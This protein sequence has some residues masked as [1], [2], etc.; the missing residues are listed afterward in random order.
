MTT[1]RSDALGDAVLDVPSLSAAQP[2]ITPYWRKMRAPWTHL[3][4]RAASMALTLAFRTSQEP[5]KQLAVAVAGAASWVPKARI[6]NMNEGSFD[7]RECILAPTPATISFRLTV[8][9]RA[10][11]RLSPAVVSPLPQT[12]VF[13]VVV[14]DAAGSEHALSSTRIAGPDA[15]NWGDL[16]LD[17]AAWG[18][19]RVELRLKTSTDRPAP[20]ERKW[21]PP[22]ASDAGTDA[23]PADVLA[24]PTMSVALWGDPVIVAEQPTRVP[25]SVLWFVVDALRPDVVSSLHETT[26]DAAKLAAPHPPLDALLPRVPGLTPSIDALAARGVRFPHA[27]SAGTWTRAGTL[28]MLAGERTS[29]LGVD[30]TAWICPRPRSRRTTP[31][32]RPWSR[33]SCAGAASPRPPS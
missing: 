10:R 28:A 19:Q 27:W 2:F 16:D 17:L 6:W 24:V 26:E 23:G 9:S 18:G 3:S 31:P 30:S 12:T 20:E 15:R 25:Y 33:S 32:I 4:G 22:V 21:A 1:R 5:E 7:E 8:P 13:D 14:L 11:L 29:E